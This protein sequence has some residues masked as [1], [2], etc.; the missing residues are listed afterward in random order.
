M[1]WTRYEPSGVRW[2]YSTSVDGYGETWVE[3]YRWS[4]DVGGDGYTAC[5]DCGCIDEAGGHHRNGCPHAPRHRQLCSQCQER[6]PLLDAE[7]V[8]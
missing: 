4:P 1:K 3:V 8:A 6:P 7:P 5:A 2:E